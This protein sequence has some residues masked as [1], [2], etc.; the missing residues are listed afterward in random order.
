MPP[1]GSNWLFSV[2]PPPFRAVPGQPSHHPR[3]CPLITRFLSV[4]C[5]HIRTAQ[6]LRWGFGQVF[7][8]RAAGRLGTYANNVSPAPFPGVSWSFSGN[9]LRVVAQRVSLIAAGQIP[10][11]WV[12]IQP[13]LGPLQMGNAVRITGDVVKVEER[14]GT[15][16]GRDWK[17]KICRVLVAKEAIYEVTIGERSPIS[18][19]RVGASVDWFCDV[20][21]YNGRL[22]I[23][24]ERD[25]PQPERAKVSA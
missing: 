8:A 5:L 19:A 22:K 12:L 9:P 11:R 10:V 23:N 17:L 18:D 24:A 16:N 15:K 3:P 6:R 25:F 2:F 20:S 7:Q 4:A 21:T 14:S 1:R 13:V